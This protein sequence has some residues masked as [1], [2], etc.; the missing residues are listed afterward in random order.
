MKPRELIRL[1]EKE[2]YVFVRQSGSHAIY[3]KA[4][5]KIIVVPIHSKDIPK[6]TLKGI[7]KDAGLKK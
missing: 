3:R 4:G 6:G 1:L 7:L 2:G 5:K